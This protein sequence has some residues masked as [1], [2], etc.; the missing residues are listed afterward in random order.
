MYMFTHT[1]VYDWGASLVTV[2]G[3]SRE[4]RYSKLADW[5]YIDTCVP[6]G[7]DGMALKPIF[8]NGYVCLSQLACR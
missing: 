2:H 7:E 1:Q 4:Q 5:E 6:R 8:G 3:R